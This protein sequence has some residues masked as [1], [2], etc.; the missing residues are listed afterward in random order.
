MS[1]SEKLVLEYLEN[2]YTG[3][4]AMKDEGCLIRLARAIVVFKVDPETHETDIFSE[5]F[6][7]N[8]FTI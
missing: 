7:E 8:I 4:R 5:K 1:E 6:I 3:A 2:A